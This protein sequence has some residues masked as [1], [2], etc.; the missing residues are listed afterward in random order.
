MNF[1]SEITIGNILTIVGFFVAVVAAF[2]GLRGKL[3]VFVVMM[4]NNNERVQRM[5]QRHESRLTKLEENDMRLTAIVQ[6]I[7]GQNSIRERWDETR[8]NQERARGRTS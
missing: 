6:E 7:I 1:S 5:E 8:R 3:D 2:Y 4:Q